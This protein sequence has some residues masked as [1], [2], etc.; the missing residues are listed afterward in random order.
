MIFFFFFF[1]LFVCFL[2][3]LFFEETPYFRFGKIVIFRKDSIDI[4]N[5]VF[6]KTLSRSIYTSLMIKGGDQ[7]LLRNLVHHNSV[8]IY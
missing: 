2:L 4:A 7:C 1:F 8:F 3:L 5:R 6:F